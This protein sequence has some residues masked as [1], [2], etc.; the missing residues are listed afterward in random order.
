MDNE[1]VVTIKPDISPTLKICARHEA[2]PLIKK[3]ALWRN[4]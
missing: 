2:E 3:E 1:G 4:K